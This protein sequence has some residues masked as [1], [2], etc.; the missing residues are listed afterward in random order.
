MGSFDAVGHRQQRVELYATLAY[1]KA[2]IGKTTVYE[3]LYDSFPLTNINVREISKQM[4]FC[5]RYTGSITERNN[6]LYH[7][8]LLLP[9]MLSTDTQYTP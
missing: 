2:F 9:W 4:L 3:E 5:Q 7:I 8:T 1:T 6:T